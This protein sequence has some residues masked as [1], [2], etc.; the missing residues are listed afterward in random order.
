[1]NLHKYI[2]DW[3]F[4]NVSAIL[5]CAGTGRPVGL[6]CISW[7]FGAAAMLTFP[8][9]LMDQLGSVPPPQLAKCQADMSSLGQLWAT[10]ETGLVSG[11]SAVS[12]P[13]SHS[14]LS[15]LGT[16]M[17]VMTGSC[18][19]VQDPTVSN[20]PE[21]HWIWRIHEG[22]ILGLQRLANGQQLGFAHYWFNPKNTENDM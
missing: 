17:D 15:A 8:L 11:I 12:Q 2:R 19:P 5:N 20:G 1:M 10:W 7:A 14:S 9:I 3:I 13:T 6:C 21:S 4:M 22:W 16:I 18:G